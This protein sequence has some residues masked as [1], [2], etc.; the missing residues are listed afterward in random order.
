VIA[1]RAAEIAKEVEL[2]LEVLDPAGLEAR[3]YLG[4]VRVGQ[5]SANPRGW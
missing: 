4:C 1:V 2:E 3:G 5:G